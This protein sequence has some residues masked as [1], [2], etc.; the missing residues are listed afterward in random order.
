MN[1]KKLLLLGGSRY[2]VPVIKS[3]KKLGVY[4]ITADYLPD[5]IA[6]KYSNHYE[7]IS[8]LDYDAL[9][10]YA[11]RESI[12]GI[13]SFACDPGVTIAARIAHSLGLPSAGPLESI[14]LLQNKKKFRAF[15][16]ENHFNVPRAVAVE[17][18]DVIDDKLR[19][20]NFPVIV[21]PTDSA[22]SKGVS[23]VDHK[24]QLHHA[25]SQAIHFSFE[26][27]CIVEEFIDSYG[28]TSDSDSFSENGE[29]KIISFSSQLF[30]KTSP[31]PYVPS[32]FSFPT[33]FKPE[34]QIELSNE[35]Q[36]LVSLLNLKTSIYNIE[37][38][39]SKE[40]KA[41]IMECSPRGGG[42]RL[43]EMLKLSQG[44][45]LI[46]NTVRSSL[47][48]PL[49]PFVTKRNDFYWSEIILHSN[50]TG[51]FSHL[52]LNDDIKPYIH[53][54]DLWVKSGD[55]ISS[56]NG[57]NSTIG[58]VICK[59][60]SSSTQQALMADPSQHINVVVENGK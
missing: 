38:R 11:K 29:M 35:I 59:F 6:H 4:T 47:G 26:K 3:A 55:K 7:N 44:T 30:D 32:A 9:L 57:A 31:N 36:R 33:S 27:C 10:N 16:T 19:D 42:N 2:L 8:I 45:D 43:S 40:G 22:G 39:V 17:E 13:C 51:T 54:I 14:L 20:I 25:I 52:Y 5:N 21:K 1:R 60:P 50:T 48:L 15:L 53:E 41:Y 34:I 49:I 56:F 37:C 46:E 28:G 58:T 12:D 23:R 18:G 24:E